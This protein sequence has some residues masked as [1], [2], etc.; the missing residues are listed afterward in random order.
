MPHHG[1]VTLRRTGSPTAAWLTAAALLLC[2]VAVAAVFVPWD[3]TVAPWPIGH[4]TSA[5]LR[6]IAQAAFTGAQRARIMD[7]VDAVW[8]PSLLAIVAGPLAAIV[9]A[10]TP[11]G[12]RIVD[13]MRERAFVASLVVLLLV[14]VVGLPFEWWSAAVR[15]DFG[16]LVQ[17]M[18][19]WWL[20]WTMT[21]AAVV[22]IGA[23]AVT[24]I[25]ATLRRWPVRGWI[26][27]VMVVGALT[28]AFSLAV[29]FLDN[30]D[31]THT[32]R[33]V[34]QRVLDIA[35]AAGVDVGDVVVVDVAD[36]S[37]ALNAHVS[38]WGPTRTVTIYDTLLTTADPA[39]VDA[40]VAHELVHV[41]HGDVIL[42]TVLAVVGAMA[43]A[44]MTA[45]LLLSPGVQRRV[46]AD[47]PGDVRFAPLVIAMA[48]AALLVGTPLAATVS[49]PL[50]AR[51]DREAIEITGDPD[52]YARMIVLLAT[53]NLSTLEPPDWRYSLFFT[54][55]TPLQ[56]L[57]AAT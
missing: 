38:G 37:P 4:A 28:A 49:R 11:L 44:A 22:L 8:L 18:G 35:Q 24:L 3:A 39:E 50:E 41:R 53:T 32:D 19:E 52:A 36:S 13:R 34:R 45:A 40:I 2:G 51:A 21:T 46:G 26:A 23:L 29:P 55:P 9:I 20:R 57:R 1:T 25:L 47:R 6:D 31:G 33:Q 16:L 42:G 15:R 48:C 43:A 5:A 7:F 17:S 56:R 10:I 27:V 12:R 14:R 54:H 30:V